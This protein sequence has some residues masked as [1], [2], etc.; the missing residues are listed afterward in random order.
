MHDMNCVKGKVIVFGEDGCNA[1]GVVRS[2]GK[3]DISPFLLLVAKKGCV[4]YS[5]YTKEYK[6]VHDYE[7]GITFLENYFVTE[8]NPPV[9]IATGDLAAGVIDKYY[10]R[11]KGH[12][13][14]SHAA[15]TEGRLIRL[16]DKEGMGKLAEE[17][18]FTVPRTWHL[19]V[20]DDMDENITYPCIVKPLKS[21][22]GRKQDIQIC[23]N[24]KELEIILSD[25]NHITK[26]FVI[27]QYIETDYEMLLIGC[28]FLSDGHTIVPGLF[29]RPRFYPSPGGPGSFGLITTK[30]EEYIDI[31]PII[32]LVEKVDYYGLFSVELG[33]RDNTPYFFEINYRNDGTSHYFDKAGINLPYLW[34]KDAMG[35]KVERFVLPPIAYYFIDEIGDFLNV[36]ERQITFRQWLADFRKAEVFMYYDKV[37]RK[38]FFYVLPLRVVWVVYRML[39]YLK[40]NIKWK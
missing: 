3:L 5:R 37:D 4:F 10:N 35:E 29:K 1:L 32:N 38:P 2:F 31:S 26:E 22:E 20:G 34:V 7:E 39:R 24:K 36:I 13:I 17:C 18:G 23:R 40:Y 11:L 27:Q 19:A 14:L 16:M 6:I 30:V 8:A 12:F 9:I 25:F 21:V 28:R 15:D 33:M